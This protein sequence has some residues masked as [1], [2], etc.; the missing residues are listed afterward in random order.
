MFSKVVIARFL[1]L[2]KLIDKM[3]II[4][5]DECEIIHSNIM[6]TMLNNQ[7]QAY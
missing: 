3:Y 7:A 4:I 1:Y 2:S 5:L 6:H